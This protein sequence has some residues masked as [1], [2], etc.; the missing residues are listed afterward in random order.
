VETP[1][2]NYIVNGIFVSA[3]Y[4]KALLRT[5][6]QVSGRW[7]N[8]GQSTDEGWAIVSINGWEVVLGR[9]LRRI[10]VP[11]RSNGARPLSNGNAG[12]LKAPQFY[13][14][15]DGRRAPVSTPD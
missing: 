15:S 7:L 2:P 6:K 11:L 4:R 8:Q 9:D 5:D 1:P 10:V 3:K 14:G 13:V 12:P